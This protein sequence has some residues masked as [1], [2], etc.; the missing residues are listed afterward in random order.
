MEQAL[1]CDLLVGYRGVHL[2]GHRRNLYTACPYTFM[3]V[4]EMKPEIK[5]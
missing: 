2:C 4:A 5:I 1:Q 3:G